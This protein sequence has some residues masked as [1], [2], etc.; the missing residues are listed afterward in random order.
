MKRTLRDAA[1]IAIAM[2]VI[3]AAGV[4]LVHAQSSLPRA[5]VN[6]NQFCTYASG[7]L[8]CIPHTSIT[9]R[10][11]NCVRANHRSTLAL[12]RCHDEMTAAAVA[13]RARR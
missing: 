12:Q 9:A 4:M 5:I 3:Y 13:K 1:I 8:I 6:G 2:V 7:S 11:T 10:Q